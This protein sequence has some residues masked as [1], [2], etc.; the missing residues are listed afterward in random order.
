MGKKA[1]PRKQHTLSSSSSA[2][3]T[4][5][6][7][8]PHRILIRHHCCRRRRRR[9]QSDTNSEEKKRPFVLTNGRAA[10][11]GPSGA[12]E[13][14]NVRVHR[15]EEPKKKFSIMIEHLICDSCS[16][17]IC[18]ELVPYS[19][20]LPCIASTER[21]KE[22]TRKKGTDERTARRTRGGEERKGDRE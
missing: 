16:I 11:E 14:V 7:T 12:A 15:K 6:T 4:T 2:A 8:T 21:R 9:D 19:P 13:R 22:R 5:N 1:R 10:D 18:R 17:S 3:A 20:K